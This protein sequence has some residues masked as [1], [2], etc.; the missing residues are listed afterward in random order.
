MRATGVYPPPM[1]RKLAKVGGRENTSGYTRKFAN[2]LDVMRAASP[3]NNQKS[4]TLCV[5]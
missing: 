2:S 3:G 4:L 1:M 5:H